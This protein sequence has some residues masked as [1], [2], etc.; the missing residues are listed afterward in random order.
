M[1]VECESC[2]LRFFANARDIGTAGRI[3]RCSQCGHEWIYHVTREDIEEEEK[4]QGKESAEQIK[5]IV[6]RRNK[7]M[8]EERIEEIG[9]RALSN[10]PLRENAFLA[11]KLKYIF[12]LFIPID[13]ALIVVIAA[14][15]M[16]DAGKIKPEDVIH[17]SIGC[18]DGRM[19]NNKGC[20]II[21][22][23][24]GGREFIPELFIRSDA[25]G[26]SHSVDVGKVLNAK[27]EIKFDF[28]LPENLRGIDN[29]EIIEVHDSDGYVFTSGKFG[30][31]FR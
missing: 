21:K 20:I 6:P 2:S 8:I 18:Q 23:S 4:I 9:Q 1:I 13:I 26:E 29:D 3:V 10:K 28:V 11:Q 14:L 5:S 12:M 22:N 27:E 17:M 25:R 30:D 15:F 16:K 31:I 24:G 19:R 7:D